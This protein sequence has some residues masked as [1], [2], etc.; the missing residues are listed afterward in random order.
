MNTT[1][2][3]TGALDIVIFLWCGRL[4]VSQNLAHMLS[5]RHIVLP[6]SGSDKLKTLQNVGAKAG[7]RYPLSYVLHQTQ[8]P[9]EIWLTP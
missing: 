5:A 6:L 3:E 8:T 7:A 4:V 1:T 9:V 2:P